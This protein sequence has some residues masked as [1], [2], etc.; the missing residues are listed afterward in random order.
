MEAC[1]TG[2][3]FKKCH[4][5]GT[6]IETLLPHAPRLQRGAGNVQPLSGWTLGDTLGLQVA[7][8]RK[9]LS[10]FETIPAL[11]ASLIITLRLLDDCSHCSLLHSSRHCH[12]EN[13]W[14]RITR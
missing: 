4:D 7:I 5:S 3:T 8:P 11:V 6:G 12:G 1:Q 14:R 13:T 2:N 10:A 9:Q